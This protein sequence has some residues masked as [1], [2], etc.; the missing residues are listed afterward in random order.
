MRFL[1]NFNINITVSIF[2]KNYP[3]IMIM[4]G[5]FYS[6]LYNIYAF[7]EVPKVGENFLSHS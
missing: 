4:A 5:Y 3:Q 6:A 2:L 7:I 1:V